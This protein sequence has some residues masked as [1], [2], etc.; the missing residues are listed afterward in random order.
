MIYRCTDG[1]C[2]AYDCQRCRGFDD[3]DEGEEARQ[4]DKGDKQREEEL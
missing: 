4:I 1:L 2:G 3:G